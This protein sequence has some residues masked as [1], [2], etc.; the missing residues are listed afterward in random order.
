MTMW[1]PN[2]P[3]WVV[4]WVGF[5]FGSYIWGGFDSP[6][7]AAFIAIIVGLVIWMLEGRRRSHNR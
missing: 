6:G 7:G 2:K 5:L 3:Q 4:I 1:F